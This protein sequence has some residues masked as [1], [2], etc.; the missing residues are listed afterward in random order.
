MPTQR[1]KRILLLSPHADDAELGAGG[2]LASSAAHGSEVMVVLATA[3]P[4]A[5]SRP[6]A[7]AIADLRMDECARAMEILG[8][9][10]LRLLSRGCDGE[11]A[12]KLPTSRLVTL[13]DGLI[14]SFAPDEVL[15]PLPSSHQD[16]MH[17]WNAGIAAT[18]PRLQGHRPDLVA[19]Y[20]YPLSH[21][22]AGAS[23]HAFQGGMYVDITP[24]WPRKVAALRAHASQM[25]HKSHHH[26]IGVEGAS[27]LA[28]LR[29]IEAGCQFAELLH[30]V[31]MVRR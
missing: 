8:V 9:Q 28:R 31:R 30:V 6:H 25:G 10:H 12:Q 13:L 15:L 4:S 21:W 27:A 11:L 26:P 22:G 17:C 3:G 29:G 24:H 5:E 16:H 19:G 1:P 18:R 2:Y 7:E 23:F 20:E 14:D